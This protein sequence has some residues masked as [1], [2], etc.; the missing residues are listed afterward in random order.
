MSSDLNCARP[1]QEWRAPWN[2]EFRIEEEVPRDSADGSQR[3]QKRVASRIVQAL[4]GANLL[5]ERG[6]V[7]AVQSEE[8]AAAMTG[9]S[10]DSEEPAI[11]AAARRRAPSL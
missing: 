10:H 2:S 1:A 6:V 3:P 7:G 9:S 8:L 5:D 4:Q 11:M